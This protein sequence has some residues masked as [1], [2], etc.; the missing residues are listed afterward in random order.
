MNV[1][2]KRAHTEKTG[3]CDYPLKQKR[4][5]QLLWPV[6]LIGIATLFIITA[7]GSAGENHMTG[8]PVLST[9]L[10]GTNEFTPGKEVQ[11][12][13]VVKN[14]EVNTVKF[15]KTG[16]IDRDDHLSTAK[17]LVVPSPVV[18]TD[19]NTYI[20]NFP[21][22]DLRLQSSKPIITNSA[23]S[24]FVTD[25]KREVKSLLSTERYL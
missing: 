2:E 4:G 23:T 13:V 18:P 1:H 20:G 19:E 8:S 12:A 24:Y 6:I 16:T 3:P 22:E 11:I 9:S 14:T 25:N 17:F 10:S 7:P 5:S 15:Q 21:S